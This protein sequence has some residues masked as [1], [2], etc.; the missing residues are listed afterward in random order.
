[1]RWAPVLLA[2]A[3]I[4]NAHAS[5]PVPQRLCVMVLRTAGH[6][7]RDYVS[8]AG[9]CYHLKKQAR[10]RSWAINTSKYSY[11]VMPYVEGR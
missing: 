7:E 10:A 8:D 9:E 5:T 3:A 11:V 2:S 4:A 1:M 6:P